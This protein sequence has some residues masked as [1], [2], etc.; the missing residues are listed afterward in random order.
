VAACLGYFTKWAERRLLVCMEPLWF[1]SG[2]P[3]GG[4]NGA[5]SGS[6]G[7]GAVARNPCV[8]WAFLTKH[9]SETLTIVYRYL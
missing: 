8:S 6:L 7:G 1:W 3:V 4:T 9:V 5:I 2:F